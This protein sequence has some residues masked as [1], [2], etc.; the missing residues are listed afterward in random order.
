MKPHEQYP[1]AH[2]INQSKRP[3]RFEGPINP[4][5]HTGDNVA[6]NDATI[7]ITGGVYIGE[8]THF[9][10]EVMILTTEHPPEIRDGMERRQTLRIQPVH[11]GTD[12]YIGSRAM[13]LKGVQIGD[14]AYIAAGAVVTKD[15]PPDTIVAGVPARPLV[16]R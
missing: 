4:V 11:I 12:V 15:V 9:G 8:R 2:F 1:E 6:I 5:F 16:R 7:D 13:I 14:R 3:F 10:H